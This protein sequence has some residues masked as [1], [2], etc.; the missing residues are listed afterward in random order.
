MTWD[1]KINPGNKEK[2]EKWQH[3]W[4]GELKVETKVKKLKMK[5]QLLFFISCSTLLDP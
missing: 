4:G 1:K 2:V 5:C 3:K